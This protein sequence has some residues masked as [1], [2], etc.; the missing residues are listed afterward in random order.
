[1]KAGLLGNLALAALVAA[2]AL[3]VYLKPG[4]DAATDFAL[5]SLKPG[6]ASLIRIER[7]GAAA[8]VLERK[9]DAWLLTAPFAARAD[10]LMVQRLLEIALAKAAHRLA[11]S[12]L[13]RF[14]LERPEARLIIDGQTFSF[15]VVSAVSREQ[16]VLTGDAVYTVSP[17]Y[18]MAL[19]GNAAD[20]I[21]RR[22]FAPDEVP[23]RI[24]LK[25]FAVAQRDGR[26]TLSPGP[27]DLSQDDLHRWVDEW[28]LATALRVEPYAKGKAQ[29]EIRLQ[30]KNGGKL[31]LGILSRGPEWVLLRPDE[32]LQ[33]HFFAEIAKR[34]LAPP[35]ATRDE[36]VKKK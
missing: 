2:L 6:A 5:S 15:G 18:G 19:P 23:A 32:R 3:F 20:L 29:G 7:D 28:Q 22:L 8:I 36:L 12:D 16:Y 24:E 9:H 27:E 4:G 35:G 34:L 30:L 33:Y 13:A 21:S 14:D 1:M 10:E 17:R 31:T 11:A 26:W 25:D